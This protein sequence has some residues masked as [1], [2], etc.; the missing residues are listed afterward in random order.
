MKKTMNRKGF[1]LIEM[2]IVIAIIAVLVAVIVPTVTGST[3]KA[4]AATNA[5]NLRGVEGEIVSMMLLEPDAF[6]DH[7]DEQGQI[8]FEQDWRENRNDDLIEAEAKL[9]AA[10]TKLSNIGT[11]RKAYGEKLKKE[12]ALELETAK[13]EIAEAES[14]CETSGCSWSWGGYEHKCSSENQTKLS[15]AKTK[16]SEAEKK[17]K[18]GDELSKTYYFDAIENVANATFSEIVSAAQRTVDELSED[19]EKLKQDNQNALDGLAAQ[20]QALYELKAVNGVITLD[21]G[22]TIQAPVSKKVNKD[23]VNVDKDVEMV[24]YV[25][26]T[27]YEAYAYYKGDKMYQSSDFAAVAGNED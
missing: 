26:N 17:E 1:T 20:E 18:L 13:N 14:V 2:M 12:A 21:N 23:A 4:A 24:V 27:T 6:G 22:T 10:Q 9:A 11:D 25:N 3:D 19:V 7:S 8:D 16:E 15:T 5:A